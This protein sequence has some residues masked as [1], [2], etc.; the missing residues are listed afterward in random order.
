MTINNMK[1]A[2]KKAVF[3]VRIVFLDMMKTPRNANT[4][5]LQF[6]HLLTLIR[7]MALKNDCQ[8]EIG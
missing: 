1:T 7:P 2:Q 6:E 8:K 3:T 5:A 4:A